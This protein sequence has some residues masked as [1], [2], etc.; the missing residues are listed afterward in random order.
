VLEHATPIDVLVAPSVEE[1]TERYARREQPVVVRGGLAD[2][3]PT[4][5]WTPE[6]LKSVYGTRRV[7]VG[8]SKTG[9]YA[10]YVEKLK[11]GVD[12]EVTFG[13][14]VDGIFSPTSEGEKCRLH[15]EPLE[16]WDT[17][18]DESPPIRY[19]TRNVV[20]KNIWMGSAGNVTKAHYDTEDNVNIQLRGKKEFI[21]YPSTQLGELYPRS[22]WD[23]MSNF[24]QV[25]IAAPDLSRY[26][27]FGR[28]TPM[29]AVIEPGD[30]L[31]IPIY[32]WH[33]VHT[34]EAS[35]NVNFWRQSRTRQSL[36]RHGVRY[37]PRMAKDG[38]LHRHVVRTIG[39]SLASLASDR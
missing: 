9:E 33:Q 26:P 36:R 20:A 12:P 18:R 10:N 27:R 38:Y 31:Y 28:A 2:W 11:T 17:F 39:T 34:L 21:L 7:K 14:V 6:Y 37:W 30:F 24:S 32:W 23:Y 25:E 19:I 13:E 1:F 35:L 8:M 3:L 15:Q 29:R 4:H 22:A 5:K 16:T